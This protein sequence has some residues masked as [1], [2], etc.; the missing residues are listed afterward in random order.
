MSDIEYSVITSDVIKSFDCN[1]YACILTLYVNT[2]ISKR[3][4]LQAMKS[5]MKCCIIRHLIR[6]CTVCQDKNDLREGDAI[7]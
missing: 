3:L 1:I 5:Q 2:G 7:I 4:L 6:V